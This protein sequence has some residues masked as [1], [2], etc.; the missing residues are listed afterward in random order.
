MPLIPINTLPTSLAG[1]GQNIIT[2][3]LV[4]LGLLPP[5]W[6]IFSKSGSSVVSFQTV[7]S[8]DYRRDWNIADY[9]LERGAFESYNKVQTP[10]TARLLLATGGSF[11]ARQR[12]I[13]SIQAIEDDM[14]L[15][16]VIT[17]E[18]TYTKCNIVHV[19]YRRADARPGIILINVHL[20]EIREAVSESTGTTAQQPSGNA[21]Q[22]GGQVQTDSLSAADKA[23]IEKAF[24]EPSATTQGAG[25]NNA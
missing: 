17:P 7:L 23:I 24:Y 20:Q 16:D 9:P 18:V 3:N 11:S 8:F 21:T 14:K 6:G 1:G 12:F 15:Y 2:D 22:S 10:F 25:V 13:E 4:G 5:S 19:D